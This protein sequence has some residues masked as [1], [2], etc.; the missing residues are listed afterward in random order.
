M[1]TKITCFVVLVLVMAIG[2]LAYTAHAGYQDKWWEKQV[3]GVTLK[4]GVAMDLN[5]S[6]HTL[7]GSTVTWADATLVE[8]YARN[9]GGEN[10]GGW[11]YIYWDYDRWQWYSNSVSVT[12]WSYY[13]ASRPCSPRLMRVRGWSEWFGEGIHEE[14]DIKL[15]ERL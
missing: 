6:N 1:R 7:W 11:P 5:R 14:H 15:T 3:A 9:V 13:P 2:L 10:C 12:G 4:Q 8:V